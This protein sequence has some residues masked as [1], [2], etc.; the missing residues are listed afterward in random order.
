ME[1]LTPLDELLRRFHVDCGPLLSQW[2]PRD[3]L[4]LLGQVDIAAAEA[5]FLAMITKGGKK[6]AKLQVFAQREILFK[7]ITILHQ[8]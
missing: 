7:A 6:D 3:R 2:E 4:N 1:E 5:F 8:S